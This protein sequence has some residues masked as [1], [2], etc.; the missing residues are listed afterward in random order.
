[1]YI[2]YFLFPENSP[3]LVIWIISEQFRKVLQMR[4]ASARIGDNGIKLV[5]RKLV[6]VSACEFL[7]EF[8]FSVMCVK[9]AATG[10]GRWRHHLTAVVREHLHCV[11]VHMTENRVLCAAGQ[12]AD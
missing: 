2:L 12:H 11:A 9:R 4:A 5:G 6:N 7:S 3:A 8:P 10:L 1:M